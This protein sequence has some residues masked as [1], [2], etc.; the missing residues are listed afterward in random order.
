MYTAEI[1]PTIVRNTAIGSCSMVARIGGIAAPYIALYLPKVITEGYAMPFH[2]TFYLSQYGKQLPMLI[3]GGSSLLGGLLAFLLPETL[4]CPLPE[5]ME[6]V[7]RMKK[8]PK[9]LCSCVSPSQTQ[10]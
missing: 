7:E 4:G 1:Y 5:R 8:N 2:S 6:D 10:D 3:L 9:P